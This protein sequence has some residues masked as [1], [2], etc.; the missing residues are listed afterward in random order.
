MGDKGGKKDKEKGKQ[1]QVKKQKQEEQRK[2]DQPP[3]DPVAGSSLLSVRNDRSCAV[4]VAITLIADARESAA[5]QAVV[6]CSGCGW[7]LMRP[8]VCARS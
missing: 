2:Q 1:Q 8:H 5:R 4:L 6:R 3:K 7:R